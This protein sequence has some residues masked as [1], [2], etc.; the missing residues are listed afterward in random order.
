L[1]LALG[2]RLDEDLYYNYDFANTE[3]LKHTATKIFEM[4]RKLEAKEKTH[5]PVYHP[6]I[7]RIKTMPL[8]PTPVLQPAVDRHPE[9]FLQEISQTR[10]DPRARAYEILE[11]IEAR[12]LRF[13]GNYLLNRQQSTQVLSQMDGTDTKHG[14]DPSKKVIF[15]LPFTSVDS[16]ERVPSSVRVI[17]EEN[18]LL[19]EEEKMKSA[20]RRAEEER[21]KREAEE[22]QQKE[23]NKKQEAERLAK[24]RKTWEE[25]HKRSQSISEKE[26]KKKNKVLRRQQEEHRRKRIEL[27]K[28]FSVGDEVV[29]HSLRQATKL[30]GVQGEILGKLRTDH[31]WPVRVTTRDGKRQT[32]NFLNTNLKPKVY[33]LTNREMSC[34]AKL[35]GMGF[36]AKDS[37]HAAMRASGNLKKALQYAT[38]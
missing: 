9:A 34:M 22:K 10:L 1:L 19:K 31:R 30:N 38:S 36:S 14:Q 33:N 5:I 13:D 15:E 23:K 29:V 18:T 20:L 6:P 4:Q 32:F 11:T 8:P 26:R 2:F 35:I 28:R 16:L 21:K 7:N 24:M 3:L 12:I 27:E 25:T 37:R 17:E